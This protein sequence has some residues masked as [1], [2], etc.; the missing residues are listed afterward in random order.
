M[1]CRSPSGTGLLEEFLIFCLSL[2]SCIL[3]SS[4]SQ[5]LIGLNQNQLARRLF[6]G[7]N[8]QILVLSCCRL[9]N[10]PGQNL[11]FGLIRFEYQSFL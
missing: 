2:R 6:L 11:N 9:L 5:L 4:F 1:S 10:Q 7:L 8:N 3:H